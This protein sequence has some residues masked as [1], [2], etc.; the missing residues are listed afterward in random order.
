MTDQ[1]RAIDAH[2]K[3]SNFD[4]KTVCFF[5]PVDDRAILTRSGFY[6]QDIEILQD[7]GFNVRIATTFQELTKADLYFVWWWTW[8][9]KPIL[10]AK[11]A[12]VPVITTG[13]FNDKHYDTRPSIERAL[14]RF[15][16]MNSH[17]NV[18]VSSQEAE[19]F[20]RR[21]PRAA[22]HYSPHGVDTKIYR[23]ANVV[24]EPFCLT[25]CWM[26]L[27]NCHRKCMFELVRAIPAIRA[28]FP[29][30]RF[31]IAGEARDG[32]PQLAALAAELGVAHAVD[33]LGP[34]SEEEKIE[35]MQS[36]A[37]Y[38]QPSR[39]EGFGL[40]IAEAMATGAP[41]VTS[42]VGAVP[43]VVGEYG[44]YVDG[45]D[46]TSIAD[47]ALQLLK[48]SD[49]RVLLGNQGADRICRQ[50]SLERRRD[51]LSGI[52]SGVLNS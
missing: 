17:A 44:I 24:R 18:L 19:W 48:N 40:A 12:R 32:G 16:V 4:G 7:L 38:L 51:D 15:G 39:Y 33:F 13:T 3:S 29:D 41:V 25:I 46:P 42:P 31:K 34:V 5:A 10:R 35:L 43:E 45:S 20:A 22:S 27:P 1:N 49:E 21:F 9:F 30:F 8:A 6:A 37:L 52:I 23:Q 50:F 36:C 2:D 11:L 14:M 26:A 47:G 28:A